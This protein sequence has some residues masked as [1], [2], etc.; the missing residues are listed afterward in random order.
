MIK[1]K[2]FHSW[3]NLLFLLVFLILS[4]LIRRRSSSLRRG[5][6]YRMADESPYI[7]HP[8]INLYFGRISS[9]SLNIKAS[10]FGTIRCFIKLE[11]VSIILQE[12]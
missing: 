12:T 6:I 8:S 5:Y 11:S 10:V 9:S 1:D 2:S 3:I 7:V 4:L